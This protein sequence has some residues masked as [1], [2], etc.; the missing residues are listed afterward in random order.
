MAYGKEFSD[1]WFFIPA[2]SR[3]C[4]RYV[5]PIFVFRCSFQ[6]QLIPGD[7]LNN[8]ENTYQEDFE[9]D[10]Q[11]FQRMFATRAKLICAVGNHDIGF[12]YRFVVISWLNQMSADLIDPSADRL[13]G[14]LI[15]KF[16]LWVYITLIMSNPDASRWS[17]EWLLIDRLQGAPI[18][19][20]EIRASVQRFS[21]TSYSRYGDQFRNFEQCSLWN[22]WLWDVCGSRGTAA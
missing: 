13:F 22:G 14:T 11:R 15:F 8:G 21:C 5:V 4:F 12:H 7:V 10:V 19:P 3:F 20:M 1:S 6:S 18:S 17:S 2:G 16:S 9:A